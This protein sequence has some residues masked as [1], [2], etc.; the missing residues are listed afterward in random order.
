MNKLTY[1]DILGILMNLDQK[2]EIGDR[3]RRSNRGKL[4]EFAFN[5]L[6]TP[7]GRSGLFIEGVGE[8][9][10]VDQ[11]GGEGQ[12]EHWHSVKYFPD[13][14]IYIKV[15]GY[16]SSYDGTEIDGWNSCSEVKPRQKVI[17]VYDRI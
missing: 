6:G 10:E 7:N 9:I 3:R 12:G 17:T 16:Y 13:H 5:D 15:T 1:D 2:E 8:Y 4:R 11:Q 14:D